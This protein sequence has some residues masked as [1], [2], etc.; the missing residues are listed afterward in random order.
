MFLDALVT[1]YCVLCVKRPGSVFPRFER[2]SLSRR[3]GRRT[4]ATAIVSERLAAPHR[5]TP[6]PDTQKEI[7]AT[8]I[9][10]FLA[11]HESIHRG[12]V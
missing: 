11:P 3:R 1:P 6:E 8:G 10:R 9:D 7:P 12:L 2:L 5:C 4:I